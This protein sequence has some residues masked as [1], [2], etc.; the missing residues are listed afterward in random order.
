MFVVTV[1]WKIKLEQAD[2]FRVCLL[3]QAKNSLELEPNCL[4]FDVAEDPTD[5]TRFFLYEVYKN[6]IDFDIH[7][8]SAHF[9]N[10]A[11]TTAHMV[12]NKVVETLH[13]IEPGI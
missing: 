6:A 11:D 13:R 4:Q 8:K 3:E 2:A 1:A 9:L 12:D 10:F 5:P 7:L